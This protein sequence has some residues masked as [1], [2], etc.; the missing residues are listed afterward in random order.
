MSLPLDTASE[1]EICLGVAELSFS[2]YVPQIM[3]K[4]NHITMS[5]HTFLA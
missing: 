1:T 2:H 3:Y 5:L 4:M